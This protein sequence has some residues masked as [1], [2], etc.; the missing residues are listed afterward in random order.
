MCNV[1]QTSGKVLALIAA[2]KVI[3]PAREILERATAS[4]SPQ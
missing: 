3:D 2:I 1:A 4:T